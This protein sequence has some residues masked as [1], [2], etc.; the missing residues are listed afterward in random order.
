MPRDVVI[1]GAGP[2]GSTAAVLL[3][4]AGWDVTLIEQSRFPRDKV[5]GECLSALGFDVLERLGLADEFVRRG[6][7]R[8]NSANVHAPSGGSMAVTLPRPMWGLSRHAFDD[9]LLDA[10][11]RAGAVVRQPARCEALDTRGRPLVR[12]RDLTTNAVETLSPSH[13]IVA[14]GKAAFA[15][16]APAPTGDFGIK[17]HFVN[18]DGPHDAIELFGVCG[19]YGGLAAIEGDR[20]NAAFSVPAAR[21]KQNR[22]DVDALFAEIA[23]ENPVLAS[24]LTRARR[25]G[26]WLASPLPRFSVRRKW[27]SAVLPVGNAAAALEPIGGEG[28]GLAM[29]S[30]ELAASA[31]LA[32]SGREARRLASEYRALWRTRRAGCR[33]AAVA[34]SSPAR[35]DALARI[36]LPEVARRLALGLM[37]K[38]GRPFAGPRPGR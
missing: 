30:A 4:R 36:P 7:L 21:L 35:M 15:T 37:G 14:D 23:R 27:P 25:V 17:A 24:R 28:M 1:I 38:T 19:S 26:E 18:V 34:V 2:A 3:A 8:L 20:W 10:A 5:C 32:G 22:G 9:M 6:A 33:A 13:V 16:D 31:L 12:L 29:R 11:G